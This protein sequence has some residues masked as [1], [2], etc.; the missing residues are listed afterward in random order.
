MTTDF[1]NYKQSHQ[2]L[3]DRVIKSTELDDNLKDRIYKLLYFLN[4][5][6]QLLTNGATNDNIN[7]EQYFVDLL[8]KYRDG[9]K[10]PSLK[11]KK[12]LAIGETIPDQMV[13]L[14]LQK[15]EK[16]DIKK[17]DDYIDGH[18]LA[19]SAENLLGSLLERYIASV[20]EDG[21]IWC[22]GQTIFATD[23]IKYSPDSDEQ[24][25]CLQVK[26]ADNSE[27]SSSSKI[28]QQFKQKGYE[29]S[30]QTWFRSR[31]KW[32]LSSLKSQV[33]LRLGI[34]GNDPL[35]QLKNKL[36]SSDESFNRSETWI[37][38]ARQFKLDDLVDEPKRDTNWDE[39][40]KIVGLSSND[41][42][43]EEKLAEYISSLYS[44]EHG[45]NVIGNT[46]E[47]SD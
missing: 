10:K 22:P 11:I 46:T 12:D 44:D 2:D 23:F 28:R 25:I 21:W 24:W 15:S 13:R 27:N 31:S 42:M 9:R 32:S 16:C 35:K 36:K 3:I 34:E 4:Q 47:N 1:T 20:I 19:M 5:F 18:N 7:T 29:D 26:N 8:T 37:S 45:E 40:N 41:S 38:I 30:I 33:Y 14:I 43:S 39:L 6:P 17:I